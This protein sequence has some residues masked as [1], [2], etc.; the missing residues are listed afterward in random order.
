MT[1]EQRKVYN[2][3]LAD[4]NHKVAVLAEA[5]VVTDGWMVPTTDKINLP[6]DQYEQAEIEG[7]QETDQYNIRWQSRINEII[8]LALDTNEVL[9]EANANA[10]G[11]LRFGLMAELRDVFW[12]EWCASHKL[13]AFW[14]KHQPKKRTVAVKNAQFKKAYGG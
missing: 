14:K 10:H 12:E 1:P 9:G 11:E 4:L 3:V 13:Y 6:Y 8:V 2:A 5:A 7:W